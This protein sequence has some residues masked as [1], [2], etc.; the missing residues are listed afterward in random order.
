M[1]SVKLGLR[2][3][4]RN[5]WRSALTLA[6]ISV[7]VGV[8]V[9]TLGFYEG[10]INEM[11]RGATSV[12]VTQ[13]Q[14]H[15]AAYVEAPRSYRTFTLDPAQMR[16]VR[17][18][19]GVVA[20]TPR[21]KLNGLIGNEQRSQVARILGVRPELEAAAT[22]VAEAVAAGRWLSDR[23]AAYPAPREVVLGE[24]MAT[25]LRA[26]VGNELVVFLE[27]ADGSLGNELLQVVGIV[28]TGNTQVDRM[29]AY[30]HLSD[31]QNMAALGDG[32]HELAIRSSDLDVAPELASAVAAALGA[33]AGA[34]P[35][36]AVERGQIAA[37]ALVVQPWQEIV[38]SLNQIIILFRQSY[39]FMYLL[40][41]LVAAIGILNTQRMSALE[42]RREFGVLMAIGMRPRRMFRTLVVET[43]VLGSVGALIGAVAGGLVTW[44]FA[45]NGLDMGLLTSAGKADFSFMGVAFS[46]RLYFGLYPGA[47]IQP[48]VVMLIVAALSGLWPAIRAARIDPAPTIAGRT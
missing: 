10:W 15:T 21:A 27:A 38:P 32:I 33:T 31:A 42:R 19:P 35:D 6:A 40:I 39:W 7:A 34:P 43:V 20:V 41:Y 11:V 48:V 4:S 12:E 29:T 16:A 30:V 26:Q 36:S 1:I 28:H 18:V 8:M 46:D 17:E 2:N 45:A 23:P 22:P 3:L 14:V 25:Q 5:R 37:D 47:V 13:A 24:G 44:Y 9:W